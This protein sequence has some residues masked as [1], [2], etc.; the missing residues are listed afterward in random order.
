M[1][2]QPRQ[3]YERRRYVGIGRLN[4]PRIVCIH[5]IPPPL[6][7]QYTGRTPGSLEYPLYTL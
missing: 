3:I 5:L 6:R 7:R 4:S 2:G 1:L